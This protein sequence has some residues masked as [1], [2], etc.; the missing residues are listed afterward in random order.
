MAE[1]G[2]TWLYGKWLDGTKTEMLDGL[3]E[4]LKLFLKLEWSGVAYGQGVNMGDTGPRYD[5]CPI[6]GG[7]DPEAGAGRDFNEKAIG[8]KKWCR[9]KKRIDQLDPI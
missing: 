5:A 7:V 4:D 6:C 3:V 1:C 8:H 9:L 2:G